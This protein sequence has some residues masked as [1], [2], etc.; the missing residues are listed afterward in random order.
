[1]KRKLLSLLLFLL[2]LPFHPLLTTFSM[3][4]FLTS[5]TNLPA[6]KVNAIKAIALPQSELLVATDKG[7]YST[8]DRGETW[9]PMQK[10]LPEG[11]VIQVHYQSDP[12]LILASVKGFGIWKWQPTGNNWVTFNNN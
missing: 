9:N 6:T 8:T 11:E 1:M 5:V 7:V 10:G 4:L 12:L 3:E 2:I